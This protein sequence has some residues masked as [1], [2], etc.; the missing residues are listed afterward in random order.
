MAQ[1]GAVVV[2]LSPLLRGTGL[3]TLLKDSDTEM[4]ITNVDFV[5]ILNPIKPALSAIKADRYWLI[6]SS[7]TE[8]YQSYQLLKARANDQDPQRI[9]LGDQDP[10]NII[11]SSGT[12]GFP[13]GIIHTHYVRAMYCTLFAAAYRISPESIVLHTGSIVFNG[14]FLT[15]MPTMYLGATYILHP[16]F[17]AEAMIRTIKEE[18][19]THIDVVPAQVIALLNSPNFALKN[20]GSLEM[21]HCYRGAPS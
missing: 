1:I 13:K 3:I 19:V 10:Y 21:F 18:R 17:D 7:A 6:D 14:A 4:V 16:Q 12:T 8:G 5:E 15:L 2:P 11:Y 20:L 9:E